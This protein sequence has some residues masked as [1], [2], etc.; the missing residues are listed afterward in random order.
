MRNSSEKRRDIARSVLPSTMCVKQTRH[1]I[2]KSER[3]RVRQFL[4]EGEYD[5]LV[6]DRVDGPTM[7]GIKEMVSDRRRADKTSQ[8]IRWAVHQVATEKKLINATHEE[9]LKEFLSVLPDNLAGRHALTHIES[10]IRPDRY[11]VRVGR[12]RRRRDEYVNPK[13][14][15]IEEAAATI[16]EA[17]CHAEFNALI[18]RKFAA[19]A[20]A[21]APKPIRRARYLEGAHDIS[22]FAHATAGA[23]EG[24]M[25]C[26]F[27]AELRKNNGKG[28]ST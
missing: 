6:P 5:G 25:S 28:P 11:S 2:H 3:A 7:R 9:R 15:R 16:I 4:H 1:Q 20:V 13:I 21:L 26:K 17:G 12:R 19:I 24:D 22:T 23:I 27:A 10:V 8:L 18:R 14:A